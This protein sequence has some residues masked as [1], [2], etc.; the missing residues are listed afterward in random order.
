MD[1]ATAAR[2]QYCPWTFF[3]DTGFPLV[4]SSPFANRNGENQISIIRLIALSTAWDN[5][6]FR[7][8]K[9]QAVAESSPLLQRIEMA[10][11]DKQL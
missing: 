9:F 11:M 10:G 6:H 8:R 3:A 7:I 2:T 4:D 1:A 5:L